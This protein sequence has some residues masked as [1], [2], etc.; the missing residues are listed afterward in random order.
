MPSVGKSGAQGVAFKLFAYTD[1]MALDLVKSESL[2]DT[3]ECIGK[4]Y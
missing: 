2:L 1:P 3:G 4:P